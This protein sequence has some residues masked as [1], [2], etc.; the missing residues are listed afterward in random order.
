MTDK[1]KTGNSTDYNFPADWGLRTPEQKSKWFTV[2]RTFRQA[3]KQDTE[4]GRR[5]RELERKS[6]E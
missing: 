4:Y 5:V 1:R 6:S 2:V 3:K